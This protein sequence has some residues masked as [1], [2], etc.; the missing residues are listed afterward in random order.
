QKQKPKTRRTAPTEQSSE[1][2]TSITFRQS[3]VLEN[4]IEVS[5]LA[6][7]FNDG[8]PD[9]RLV[10][11]D[12]LARLY[13]SKLKRQKNTGAWQRMQTQSHEDFKRHFSNFLNL[14]RGLRI[15]TSNLLTTSSHENSLYLVIKLLISAGDKVV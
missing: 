10:H 12:V 7:Q 5:S 4:P 8:W 1:T 15:S 3:S 14:T 11:T 2:R 13:V 6:Y 9:L